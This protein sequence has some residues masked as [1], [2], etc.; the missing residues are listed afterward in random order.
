MSFHDMPPAEPRPGDSPQMVAALDR[1]LLEGVDARRPAGNNYQIKVTW[2]VSY[3]PSKGSILPD[4]DCKLK[5]R[6]L[7]ALIDYLRE[8]GRLPATC[9]R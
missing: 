4:Q 6:G 2:D 5:V 8:T 3:Y 7:D 9:V 1:L